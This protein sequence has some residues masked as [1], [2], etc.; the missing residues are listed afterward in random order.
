MYMV[1]FFSQLNNDNPQRDNQQ[2]KQSFKDYEAM[3]KAMLELA[4]KQEGYIDSFSQ[5]DQEGLGSTISL[6]RDLAAIEAWKNNL[7]H[8]NAKQQGRLQWYKHYTLIISKIDKLYTSS[9][10]A[11]FHLAQG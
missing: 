5:R 8:L 11:L 1:T 7:A 10:E 6:W 2:G 3:A 4:Q 9:D